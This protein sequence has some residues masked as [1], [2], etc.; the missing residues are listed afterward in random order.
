MVLYVVVTPQRPPQYYVHKMYMSSALLFFNGSSDTCIWNNR[1]FPNFFKMNSAN[2][3]KKKCKIER[4]TELKPA[5]LQETEML[6]LCQEDTG[7]TED[8]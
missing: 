6:P 4:I 7:N 2:S 5:C 1:V 3:V 8:H